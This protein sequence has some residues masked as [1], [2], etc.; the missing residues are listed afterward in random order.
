[1]ASLSVSDSS[2]AIGAQ[3]T[4]SA[5]VRNIGDGTSAATTLRY[6]RSADVTISTSDTEVGRDSVSGLA[7]SK[8]VRESVELTA[9]STAGTYYYG[10]CVDAVT[11]ESDT[12]NNCSTS[13]K[14][15][16]VGVLESPGQPDLVVTSP[17]LSDSSPSAGAQFT[18]SAMVRN[19]GDYRLHGV[20][21]AFLPVDGCDD[22]HIG[23][24]DRHGPGGRTSLSRDQ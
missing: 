9:P 4:L 2:P 13:V 22:L 21:A 24:G 19:D 10:A 18:L 23:H 8:S 6:Y 3:F 5:P 20:S 11:D 14:I 1:M 12:T 7:A 15:S 17:S 16:V